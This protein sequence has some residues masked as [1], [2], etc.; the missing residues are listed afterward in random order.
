MYV[1]FPDPAPVALALQVNISRTPSGS[2]AS[3]PLSTIRSTYVCPMMVGGY[4][5]HLSLPVSCYIVDR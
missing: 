4:L 2:A 5:S 1:F 3:T